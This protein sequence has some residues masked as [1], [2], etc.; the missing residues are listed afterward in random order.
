MRTHEYSPGVCGIIITCFNLFLKSTHGKEAADV[1]RVCLETCFRCHLPQVV[2]VVKTFSWDHHSRND[3]VY[4]GMLILIDVPA[5]AFE[6]GTARF[7]S[8]D[9]FHSPFASSLESLRL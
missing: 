6:Y 8:P 3:G 1:A 7:S 2:M 9:S 5:N 4:A